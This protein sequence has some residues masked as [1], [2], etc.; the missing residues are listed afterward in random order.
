MRNAA[1]YF[2]AANHPE[3]SLMTVQ[4]GEEHDAR[5]IKVRGRFENVPRQRDGRRKNT[6][7]FTWVPGVQRLNRG[8]CGGGDGVEDSQQRVTM[9]LP[10]AT[11]QRGIIKIVA[12]VHP[13]ARG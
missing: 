11:D 12:S 5:F 10:V 9:M 4:P 2:E 3:V 6:I 7:K 13:N 1:R 8:R